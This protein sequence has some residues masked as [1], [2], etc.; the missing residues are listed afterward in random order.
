MQTQPKHEIGVADLAA[1]REFLI[2]GREIPLA[3]SPRSTRPSARRSVAA[4][5]F[6]HGI[7]RA[8]R[9]AAKV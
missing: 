4:V 3:P 6:H 7:T 2:S 1:V 5:P 9:T 8:R